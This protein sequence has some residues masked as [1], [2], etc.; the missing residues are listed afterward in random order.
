MMEREI[1]RIKIRM[2]G[3]TSLDHRCDF[4]EHINWTIVIAYVSSLLVKPFLRSS[5][6]IHDGNF[7]S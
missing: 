3:A 5:T 2:A 1:V 4:F 6:R 7:I